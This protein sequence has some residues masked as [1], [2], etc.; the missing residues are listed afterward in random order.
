MVLGLAKRIVGDCVAAGVP[1]HVKQLGRCP[2]NREGNLH[3]ISDDK[4]KFMSEWPEILRI[5][6]I[7]VAA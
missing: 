2:T 6:E 5:Q 7:P 3:S 1:V 4:G